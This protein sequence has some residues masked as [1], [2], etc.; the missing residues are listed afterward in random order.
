[1]EKAITMSESGLQQWKFHLNKKKIFNIQVLINNVY[2]VEVSIQKEAKELAP[3]TAKLA[4]EGKGISKLSWQRI[5]TALELNWKQFFSE[6]EWNKL[7]SDG[8]WQCLLDIADDAHDRFG[9]VLAPKFQESGIRD[10]LPKNHRYKTILSQGTN[11]FVEF[12]ADLHGSLIL[13]EHNPT[14]GFDLAAPS[15]FMQNNLLDGNLQQLPQYPPAHVPS[16]LLESLGTSTLWA[17]V[18]DALPQW[19]WLA[20]AK[21]DM[22][23]LDVEQLAEILE[24]AKS[25]HQATIWRSSYTVTAN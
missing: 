24:F 17:G 14:G 19:D 20:D 18:F 3:A 21:K 22:L 4:F 7:T 2:D 23:A 8:I 16:I 10:A 25:Q 11:V 15:C 13:L 12:P 6:Y 1:M 5:F 9:L